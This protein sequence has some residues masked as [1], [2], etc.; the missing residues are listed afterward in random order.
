M[1]GRIAIVLIGLS[2]VGLAS[3]CKTLDTRTPS[4][5][6]EQLGE[7]TGADVTVVDPSGA[8]FCG[9]IAVEQTEDSAIALAMANNAAF[10]EILCD[11]GIAHADVID[12]G[13]IPNPELRFFA[14]VAPRPL[15]SYFEFPIDVFI[16]RPKRV[17][18][19]KLDEER[20]RGTVIQAGLTLARD[21]RLAYADVLLA[22]DRQTIARD[23]ETLRQRIAG[24]AEKRLKAGDATPV[25]IAAARTDAQRSSQEQGR[26]V[27]DLQVALERFHVLLGYTNGG[28]PMTATDQPLP[29]VPASA[30]EL[31]EQALQ[32]RPDALAAQHAAASAQAKQK[33]ARCDWIRFFGTYY[34]FADEHVV[35]HRPGFRMTLPIFNWNQGKIARAD[36]D[37]AK[38]Q[39]AQLT[40][41]DRIVL[42]T[43]QA[44]LQCQQAQRDL[45]R[46]QTKIRPTVEDAVAKA[47]RSYQAG[48]TPLVLVLETTRQVLEMRL[49]EAQLR[50]DLRK[51][52]AE[53]ERSVGRKLVVP[54]QPTL[55]IELP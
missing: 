8:R 6:A 54:R 46:W 27:E 31:I 12:A 16:L 22:K 2:T 33:L 42:E 4:V 15:E 44:F 47:E 28:Q 7:R 45:E 43:R 30:D 11:L 40:V 49:R 14:P 29:T 19:A 21:V 17:A 24:L 5:V 38:A 55:E 50:A 13:I 23:N 51:A 10:R 18:I 48:D 53:L 41:H 9:P 39:A 52:F 3:G 32:T 1:R 25:E 20:I 36:A 26:T 37:L 35:Q 34:T